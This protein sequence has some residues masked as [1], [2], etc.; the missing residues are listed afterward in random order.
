MSAQIVNTAGLTGKVTDAEKVR[1]EAATVIL[2]NPLDSAII[3]VEISND[4][5]NFTFNNLQTGSYLI[6]VSSVGYVKNISGPYLLQ[7]MDKIKNIGSI[8]LKLYNKLLNE[9]DIEGKNRFLEVTAGKVSLNVAN[10]ILSSGSTAFDILNRAPGVQIDNNDQI[11]LNGKAGVLVMVNGKETFMETANLIDMLKSMQSS[12]IESIDLISSPSA[13][14]SAS[15][16][17]SI[18]NIKIKKNKNYGTNGV[19]SAMAGIGSLGDNYDPNFKYNGG[20]TINHRNKILNVF[21]NYTHADIDQSKY[22]TSNRLMQNLNQTAIDVNYFSK[23][24]RVSNNYRAGVDFNVAPSQIIGLLYS[25]SRNDIGIDKNNQ[26]DIYNQGKVDSTIFAAS[27]QNRLLVNNNYNL[28]YKGSLG[29][30]I[31]N[32]SIDFDYLR[33]KRKSIEMLTNTFQTASGNTYRDELDLLNNSPSNYNIKSVKVDYTFPFNKTSSL[34]LGIQASNVLGENYLNFGPLVN[35]VFYPDSRFTNTYNIDE[36]IRAAFFSYNKEFKNSSLVIGL[37]AEQTKTNG[38][39]VTSGANYV[40]NY[41]DLF[42]NLQYT[43]TLNKNNKLLLSLGRRIGRPGYEALNPFLAYLDQYSFKSGN[44][45]LKPAYTQNAEATH[46]YKDNIST[47]L[48]VSFVNDVFLDINNQNDETFVNTIMTQNLD[49]QLTYG[50]EI[51]APLD[52]TDWW[53]IELNFQANMVSYS[54]KSTIGAYTNSSP[55]IILNTL[56]NFTLSK[57]IKAEV[58]TE[59]ENPTVYGIYNFDASYNVNAGFSASMFNKQGS[60]KLRLNDIFNI[61]Q[62]RYNSFYENLNLN[63]LN[64]LESRTAQLSFSYSFGKK[65]IKSARRRSTGSETEQ[66]RVGN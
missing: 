7:S 64:K 32:V 19:V 30:K 3:K 22:I 55:D 29:E 16:I 54:T 8:E 49:K 24:Q 15:G 18:I 35:T 4:Q 23:Q 45:Y 5:G 27:G 31:G 36:K 20:L 17:A 62:S 52:I 60:L 37:R 66:N 10:S 63:M 33:Y 6:S 28:N 34:D 39:S 42:P 9:V 57:N 38:Q 46:V 25:G 56:Q 48:R 26:T 41:T 61:S 12:N 14:Y 21:G 53:N 43:Q 59:Y 51:N 11:K 1:V 47:T 40:R 2:L 58:S 65:T 50:L 13:K 44:P